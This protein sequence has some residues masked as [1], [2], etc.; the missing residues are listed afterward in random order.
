MSSKLPD[1]YVRFYIEDG[2]E[3]ATMTAAD[4]RSAMLERDHEITRLRAVLARTCEESEHVIH[5]G[6]RRCAC[7][8][9]VLA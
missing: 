5:H 7:G 3:L 4:F 9:V 1:P 8:Q 6:D 2:T